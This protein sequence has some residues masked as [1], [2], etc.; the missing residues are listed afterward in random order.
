MRP[1]VSSEDK[2]APSCQAGRRETCSPASAMRPSIWHKIAVMLFARRVGPVGEAALRE[3]RAVPADDDAVFEL[4]RVLRMDLRA[5]F[6]GLAY[7]LLRR[8]RVELVGVRAPHVAAEQHALAAL[9]HA[10]HRIADHLDRQVGKADAAVDALVLF[11]E[12][13]LELQSE[14]DRRLVRRR[15]DRRQHRFADLDRNLAQDRQRDRAQAPVG[16][17]VLRLAAAPRVDVGHADAALVLVDRG[18]LRIELDQR[19]DVVIQRHRDAIH[20]ADR[21]EHRRRQVVVERR[22]HDSSPVPTAATRRARS[23]STAVGGGISAGAAL[24]VVATAL[25]RRKRLHVAVVLVEHAEHAQR[26]EQPFLVLDRQFGIELA[27]V[28]RLAQQLGDVAVIVRVDVPVALRLAAERPWT[29]AGR[30]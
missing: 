12:T 24:A 3:R 27:L 17:R 2:T 4:R 22:N 20:A 29:N 26:L 9:V 19:G 18:H 15:L 28:D 10:G 6:D 7:A 1:I 16:A 21:L 30:R 13:A 25:A 23:A 14:L 5:N 8:H 11:P